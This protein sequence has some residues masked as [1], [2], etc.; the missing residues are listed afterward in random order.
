MYNVYKTLFAV[1]FF[2]Y[3]KRSGENIYIKEI[4]NSMDCPCYHNCYSLEYFPTIRTEYLS[5]NESNNNTYT[6]LDV[7]FH[8]ESFIVYKTKLAFTWLDLMGI[9]FDRPYYI[10][11]VNI[12]TNFNQCFFYIKYFS[13][14]WWH[15][16]IIFGL[17]TI[18]C[19]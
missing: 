16:W 11:S 13:C 1:D 9:L 7:H 2:L 5:P 8:T 6:D 4:P 18:E 15:C 14:F 19:C 12:I 10:I 3:T 17:F